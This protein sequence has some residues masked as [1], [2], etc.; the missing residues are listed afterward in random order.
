MTLSIWQ[1]LF[2]FPGEAMDT[3]ECAFPVEFAAGNFQPSLDGVFSFKYFSMQF[4]L[5]TPV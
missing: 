1:L 5:G 3:E 4:V 2:C